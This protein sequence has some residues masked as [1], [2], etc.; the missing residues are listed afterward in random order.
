MNRKMKLP[1]IRRPRVPT[2]PLQFMD[3]KHLADLE[4]EFKQ[5]CM[6]ALVSY[7][8][9]QLKTHMN[10]QGH[11]DPI[12]QRYGDLQGQ[13]LRAQAANAIHAYWM[14]RA[15]YRAAFQQYTQQ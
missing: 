6:R 4:H 3:L 9:W 2:K 12:E 11:S 15:D 13:N 8:K 10:V 1:Q 14:V 5:D 7:K